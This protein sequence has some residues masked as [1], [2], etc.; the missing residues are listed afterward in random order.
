MRSPNRSRFAR[1]VL[2][3]TLAAAALSLLP[4]AATGC[5]SSG[6]K[7][8]TE[9]R[10]EAE[11]TTL[12]VENRSFLDQNVYVLRGSQRIRLGTVTGSRT[13]RF[14]IPANL[15]FG[16]SSLRFLVDPIGGNR[17]PVTEEINV[18]PGDEVQLVIPP[19]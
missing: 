13:Q 18:S 1:R 5:A 16:V 15:I 19:G 6:Q 11:P 7:A 12:L 3:R 17:Q 8:D 10:P 2:V 14:T 9:G 4:V